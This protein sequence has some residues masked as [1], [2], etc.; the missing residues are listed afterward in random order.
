MTSSFI[1][2]GS[3]SSID[4]DFHEILFIARES[5]D[6]SVGIKKYFWMKE[7]VNKTVKNGG[8]YY[9]CIDMIANYIDTNIQLDKCAYMNINKRGGTAKC[10]FKILDEYARKYN[11]FITKEIEIINPKYIVILGKLGALGAKTAEKI[12]TDYAT[13]HNIN[14]YVYDRHPCVYSKLHFRL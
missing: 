6:N 10:N 13:A 9:N 4:L 5:H 8:K 7:V 11:K 2:D 3:F 12:I 14:A 1:Y